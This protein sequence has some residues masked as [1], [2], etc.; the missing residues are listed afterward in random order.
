MKFTPC[1]QGDFLST[2]EITRGIHP[3]PFLETG[4][5][6]ALIKTDGNL[7]LLIESLNKSQ[8]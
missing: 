5:L 6:L 3:C 2:L 1:L 7:H 4:I 8:M